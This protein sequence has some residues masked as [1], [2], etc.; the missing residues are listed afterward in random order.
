M[1]KKIHLILMTTVVS[2]GSHAFAM[3]SD[4]L[5]LHPQVRCVTLKGR[6]PCP[7]AF[8]G[9]PR[10][11]SF[12]GEPLAPE[13]LKMLATLN[14]GDKYK[15]GESTY[16]VTG[17]KGDMRALADLR[18]DAYDPPVGYYIYRGRAELRP[19]YGVEDFISATPKDK[20]TPAAAI[21]STEDIDI[22][23]S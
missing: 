4:N 9:A 19:G 3:D 17:K 10:T 6:S 5:A 1:M 18:A 2:L 13:D 21:Y 7:L 15:Y 11:P 16:T 12:I 8:I 14:I 20:A 22:K 23:G